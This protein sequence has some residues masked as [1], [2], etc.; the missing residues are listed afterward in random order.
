MYDIE[1]IKLINP[2]STP[3][4]HQERWYYNALNAL[5]N[6]TISFL[7]QQRYRNLNAT[8]ERL[9][10]RQDIKRRVRQNQPIPDATTTLV[11][12]IPQL[13]QEMN[14]LPQPTQQ[15]LSRINGDEGVQQ[16]YQCSNVY[17][18]HELN[19]HIAPKLNRNGKKDWYNM[20]NHSLAM[21][22]Y[23]TLIPTVF[24]CDNTK[25]TT[26]FV[27]RYTPKNNIQTTAILFYQ[28]RTA[29]SSQ[30]TLKN[31]M[32]YPKYNW[33]FIHN[34]RLCRWN[35]VVFQNNT[36]IQQLCSC[37]QDLDYN[38]MLTCDHYRIHRQIAIT[39]TWRVLNLS[40]VAA[41]IHTTVQNIPRCN[42]RVNQLVN[43]LITRPG[44][45]GDVQ[46][47]Q[48]LKS[49]SLQRLKQ[50]YR[51]GR[52]KI[53]VPNKPPL[54]IDP[55]YYLHLI[56]WRSNNKYLYRLTIDPPWLDDDNRM[57]IK[58]LLQLMV[59]LYKIPQ[60]KSYKTIPTP[61]T[62]ESY[63]NRLAVNNHLHYF[64]SPPYCPDN[65]IYGTVLQLFLAELIKTMTGE[66]KPWLS[67][68]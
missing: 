34:L 13:Q 60:F 54:V 62:I 49:K 50:H 46:H 4:F 63:I 31:E 3:L 10:T 5:P 33:P 59:L 64:H 23:S 32:L 51:L 24:S 48:A 25:A 41:Q 26:L 20:L 40:S 42:S 19:I 22:K 16:E 2:P 15:L 37:G 57:T 56:R 14:L 53:N 44:I 27:N 18:L 66:L 28:R 55:L 30:L 68:Y 45:A 67:P 61:L 29:Q 21:S 17:E 39:K 43:L 9:K 12:I 11:P 65:T 35:G 52:F 7:C 38:H 1:P 6:K 8:F 47:I 58:L 36:T